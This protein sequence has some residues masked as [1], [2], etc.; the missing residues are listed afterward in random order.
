[1]IRIEVDKRSGFCTGIIKAVKTSE[2][3]LGN[4]DALYTLGELVHNPEEVKRLKDMGLDP[5]S[6][7]EFERLEDTTVLIRAHGEPPATFSKARQQNIRLI[8]ATCPIVKNLQKKIRDCYTALRVKEGSIL[9]FGK[10]SHPEVRALVA[11]TEG[12]AIVVRDPGELSTLD[13]ESPVNLFSQTTMNLEEYSQFQEALKK[14]MI[15]LGMNQGNDLRTYN[16]VCKQVSSREKYLT[17]FVAGYDL[18]FFVSGK[19]SSN[20]KVLYEVCR[21]VNKHTCFISNPEESDSVPL[22]NISSIGICG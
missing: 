14:R 17:E 6:Y 12:S 20:G 22:E 2:E 5:V 7:E 11:Q 4:N 13:L 8:D 21:K 16:T 18:V 15:E 3:Y 19:E 1:M 9:I 10:S